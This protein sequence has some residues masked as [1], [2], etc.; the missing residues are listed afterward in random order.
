MRSAWL[1]RA[2]TTCHDCLAVYPS[3]R[4]GFEL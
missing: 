1:A 2:R 3:S 4:L